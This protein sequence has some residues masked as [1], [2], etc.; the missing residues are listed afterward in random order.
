MR[1]LLLCLPL[2]FSFF[3]LYGA[4]RGAYDHYFALEGDAILWKRSDGFKPF[5]Q[6][7]VEAE[8]DQSQRGVIKPAENLITSK[9][10]VKNMNERLGVR[11]GIKVFNSLRSTWSL[12]YTGFLHWEGKR[13]LEHRSRLVSHPNVP[14]YQDADRADATYLSDFWSVD[15]T[16]WDYVTPRYSSAV[17][18][19]WMAGLRFFD[20]S[21]KLKLDFIKGKKRNPYH[22]QTRNRPVGPF[23]GFRFECN[24]HAYITWGVVANVGGLINRSRRK[25]TMVSDLKASPTQKREPHVTSFAYFVHAYPFI[26]I[27]F[28]KFFTL[29]AGYDLLYIDR[30]ALADRDFVGTQASTR[31]NY[32][33]NLVYYGFFAGLQLNF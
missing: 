27:R 19:A 7:L 15:L 3:F 5:D 20:L 23:I 31:K 6:V 9:Q 25:V 2:L 28:V 26:D 24:P 16:H 13:E 21:E 11:I 17:S 30:L 18:V 8:R 10:L 4:E 12:S 32:K 33:G 1:T 14:D 29:F 22:V